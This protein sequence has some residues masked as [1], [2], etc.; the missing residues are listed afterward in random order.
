M[1]DKYSTFSELVRSEQAEAFRVEIQDA[2]SRVA[3][4]APHGG[5]IEPGT[6]EVSRAIARHNF[7]LY[8]FEGM[9]RQANSDLHITSTKFD[10]PRC[11]ALVQSVDFAVA[12]HG[13]GGDLDVAYLGGRNVEW[14]E[15]LQIELH[16]R[17]FRV[18][19][20]SSSLLQGTD[21][22]NV[23]NRCASG[24]GL[25]LELGAGLRRTFFKSL[26]S[27]AARLRTTERFAI[28]TEGVR[29]VLAQQVQ[30][31]KG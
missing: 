9:K 12:V 11:L 27:S 2:K 23:C 22:A 15:R 10:E 19:R 13:E 21:P 8:L 24:L 31:L 25:Q 28:F 1:A 5:G 29:S 16:E 14:G 20:H 6:S 7:S 4:I 26:S 30:Q 18:E 3:V 17:G